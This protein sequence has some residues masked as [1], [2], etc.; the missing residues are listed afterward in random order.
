MT[1][2]ERILKKLRKASPRVPAYAHVPLPAPVRE[3]Q[4]ENL[5]EQFRAELQKNSTLFY[6]CPHDQAL[7][8]TL[9]KIISDNSQPLFCA[10]SALQ[11]V[12]KK[13]GITFFSHN[14]DFLKTNTLLSTAECLIARSGSLLVSAA[15]PAGRRGNVFAHNHIVVGR[16]EQLVPDLKQ[17]YQLVFSRY[18]EQLPSSL[19]LITGPSRTADI[20]K[21]LVLGAHGPKKLTVIL[22]G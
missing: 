2:K 3:P 10:E 15:Q 21:T 11:E 5:A 20:E 19:S 14:T 4:P 1:A 7:V 16:Q 6:T 8:E 12:L 9:K 13:A 17:A 18:K 22:V